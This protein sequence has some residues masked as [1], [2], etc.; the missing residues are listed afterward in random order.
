[1]R[2]RTVRSVLLCAALIFLFGC[3]K[4]REE[5][6]REAAV[7]QAEQLMKRMAEVEKGIV[8]R[9]KEGP[10]GVAA[11]QEALGGG[12]KVEAVDFRSLQALLPETL[13]NMK[14]SGA[15]GEKSGTPGMMISTA[16]A[17]YEA[18]GGGSIDITISDLGGMSG[19]PAMLATYAW[20]TVPI[21]RE[22]DSGYEKTTT[23]SGYR[24]FENYDKA[25][26]NGRLQILVGGRFMV[27][28]AGSG[29]NMAAI[30]AAA[31]K[32]DL[33]GLEKMKELGVQK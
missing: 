14:R 1:M 16:E 9:A 32:V 31:G 18:D 33:A 13:P 7:K 8:P 29:V 24:A 30:K 5:K 21:D 4:S 26:Q 19:A 15:T 23:F 25:G 11:L 28:V 2:I 10:E 22:T 17:N 3:G 12:K 27:E 20:A 6:E